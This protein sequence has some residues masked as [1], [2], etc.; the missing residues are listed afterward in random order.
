MKT[1]HICRGLISAVLILSVVLSS[2]VFASVSASAVSYSKNPPSFSVCQY[3]RNQIR[4]SW[5]TQSGVKY[6][7]LYS[8]R[9]SAASGWSDWKRE[10]DFT[11]N[12]AVVT[13]KHN[14]SGSDNIVQQKYA[15]RCVSSESNPDNRKWLSAYSQ[16]GSINH[17]SYRA[18]V[19]EAPTK[20]NTENGW[21]KLTLYFYA[22]EDLVT[23]DF[24]YLNVNAYRPGK[25]SQWRFVKS[26]RKISYAK[27]WL[28][29]KQYNY[30]GRVK[31]KVELWYDWVPYP[32]ETYWY[33]VSIGMDSWV[34]ADEL[35]HLDLSDYYTVSLY[36]PR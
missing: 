14:N 34:Y 6:Y 32:G 33:S 35:W 7:R 18:P 36:H 20:A 5:S 29:R 15:M 8:K 23:K 28:G 26:D 4:V 17:Y 2:L 16:T 21:N 12:S 31:C 9:Y 10:G 13:V 19:V 24:L 25:D 1:K 22:D 11:G 27:D 3:S 30:N